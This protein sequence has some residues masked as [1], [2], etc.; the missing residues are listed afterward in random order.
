MQYETVFLKTGTHCSHEFTQL[1]I[2]QTPQQWLNHLFPIFFC[3]IFSFPLYN[4]TAPKCLDHLQY[5][6]HCLRVKETQQHQQVF[7]IPVWNLKAAVTRAVTWS[8]STC[9]RLTTAFFSFQYLLS[10]C[11]FDDITLRERTPRWLIYF[12]FSHHLLLKELKKQGWCPGSRCLRM[13]S[14][15]MNPCPTA[16]TTLLQTHIKA[17]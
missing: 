1:A 3:F 4:S 5:C 15:V 17:D 6:Y 14:L 11:N 12:D 8:P 7:L 16:R 10:H 13:R 9:R 2:D